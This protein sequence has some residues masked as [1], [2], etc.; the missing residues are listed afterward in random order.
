MRSAGEVASPAGSGGGRVSARPAPH[1][2]VAASGWPR[3]NSATSLPH[4]DTIGGA[5]ASRQPRQKTGNARSKGF[6]SNGGDVRPGE[7]AAPAVA[8]RVQRRPYPQE[9]RGTAYGRKRAPAPHRGASCTGPSAGLSSGVCRRGG[10][11]E[12]QWYLGDPTGTK[13]S[14]GFFSWALHRVGG[15]LGPSSGSTV[16]TRPP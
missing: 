9:K 2:V 4:A 5:T 10:V 6:L 8:S 11:C 3:K 14:V 1:D 7:R 12:V 16:Q 15:S 13:S